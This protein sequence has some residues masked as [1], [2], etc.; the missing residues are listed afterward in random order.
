[1]PALNACL[2]V[3]N[4][5]EASG[6]PY[7]ENVAKVAVSVFELLEHK[8]KNKKNVKEL[9][10]S[11][12]NTIAV[13]D[14]FVRMHGEPEASHFKDICG[15]MEKYLESMA[16][17]LKDIKRKHRG[18]KGVFSVHDFRD[19]IQTYRRRVDDLK[20]DFLIHSVGDCRLE[21]TQIQSLLKDVAAGAVVGH[22]EELVFRI[23]KKPVAITTFFFL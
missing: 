19:A 13:I 5:A 1:M 12:A 17:E 9:C 14:A 3:A 8:G 4:I 22:S 7:V 2:K 20:T 11:I 21:V 16:Q 10:E 18:L 15:E 6:V 23:P